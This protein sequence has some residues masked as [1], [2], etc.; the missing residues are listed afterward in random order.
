[1]SVSFDESDLPP[2][3]VTVSDKTWRRKQFD[4]AG[5]QWARPMNADEYD[6]DLN[7][8]SLVGT[9]E[10][11]RVVELQ[12]L[13]EEW[14][15][16]ASETAGPESHRPGFTEPIGGSFDYATPEFKDAVSKVRDF[17]DNLTPKE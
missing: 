13:D 1:M 15:V 7:D 17:I 3:E 16:S 9:D 14:H 5:Y 2:E 11:I 4:T 8:V 10:P 6:W 12:Y